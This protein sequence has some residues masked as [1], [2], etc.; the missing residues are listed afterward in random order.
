MFVSLCVRSINSFASYT[1]AFHASCVPCPVYT[2][3]H[4]VVMKEL[5]CPSSTISCTYSCSN[6]C[7]IQLK[8]Y[9]NDG[10][11]AHTQTQRTPHSK[12]MNTRRQLYWHLYAKRWFKMRHFL[13]CEAIQ[14]IAIPL[15]TLWTT[16][17]HIWNAKVHQNIWTS[18]EVLFWCLDCVRWPT[19]V[20]DDPCVFNKSWDV[21]VEIIS[22]NTQL[23]LV[24]SSSRCATRITL[25]QTNAFNHIFSGKRHQSFVRV[26]LWVTKSD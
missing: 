23:D 18:I 15:W 1:N 13:Q 21:F 2:P 7:D 14:F 26:C 10:A 12:R 22:R 11:P 3:I 5:Q 16:N 4:D 6:E 24:Q 20:H 8:I 9:I 25:H 17:N 19:I